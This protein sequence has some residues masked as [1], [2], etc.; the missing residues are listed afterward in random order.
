M[1]VDPRPV[2][3]WQ[4]TLSVLSGI[5]ESSLA[6]LD[7][8]A[9]RVQWPWLVFA[10]VIL[11]IV[12]LGIHGSR[13]TDVQ[14]PNATSAESHAPQEVNLIPNPSFETV[15]DG[16]PV[17]WH[18]KKQGS[19]RPEYEVSTTGHTGQ[20]ALGAFAAIPA[21]PTW[22]TDVDLVPGANYRLVA[23]IKTEDV[24]IVGGANGAVVHVRGLGQTPSLDGTHDWT[25][26]E[27][28]F[29][30]GVKTRAVVVCHLGF[31]G[32]ATGKAWFDDLTLTRVP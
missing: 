14:A 17:A 7:G 1:A 4:E 2:D 10:A 15:Q 19:A 3:P 13:F 26:V 23:W 21:S 29:R 32:K 28:V 25:R 16:L 31:G 11:A 9:S 12:L 6:V 18:H 24:K 5:R 8:V 22:M 30:A 20:H 27:S